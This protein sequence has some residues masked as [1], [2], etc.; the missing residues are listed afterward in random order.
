MLGN[1]SSI[2]TIS[3]DFDI[4]TLSRNYRHKTLSTISSS[5]QSNLFFFTEGNFCSGVNSANG[6]TGSYGQGS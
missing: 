5:G 2:N 3:S 6:N 4:N 1:N